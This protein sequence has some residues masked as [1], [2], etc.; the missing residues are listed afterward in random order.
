MLSVLF[1]PARGSCCKMGPGDS[2]RGASS[3]TE[4][5]AGIILSESKGAPHISQAIREGSFKNVH[6][7]H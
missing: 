6:L 1:E 3:G 2:E 7:G 4:L 5:K